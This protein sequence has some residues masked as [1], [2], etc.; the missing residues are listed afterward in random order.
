MSD[1]PTLPT[2]ICPRC[3][4]Y[5]YAARMGIFMSTEGNQ[6]ALVTES[7]APCRMEVDGSTPDLDRCPL[8]RMD[9]FVPMLQ[10][11]ANSWRFY[12]GDG[13]AEGVS[14]TERFATT[15]GRPL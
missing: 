10:R 13:P 12:S 14:L 1:T 8:V 6:C 3:P 5:G 2:P 4:F 9:E 15:M 7:H 11:K